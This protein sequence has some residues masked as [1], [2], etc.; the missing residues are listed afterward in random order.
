MNEKRTI[1]YSPKCHKSLRHNLSFF[2]CHFPLPQRDAPSLKQQIA[3]TRHKKVTFVPLKSFD[4]VVGG[5]VKSSHHAFVCAF[6]SFQRNHE[7]RFNFV[8]F[9]SQNCL[10][11]LAVTS[12]RVHNPILAKFIRSKMRT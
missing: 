9:W 12:S 3:H 5:V 6:P 4:F 8:P 1:Q 2:S 10:V 7:R 11:Y